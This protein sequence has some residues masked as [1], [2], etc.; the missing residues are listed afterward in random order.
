M[1]IFVPITIPEITILRWMKLRFSLGGALRAE[2]GK[3]GVFKV[4]LGYYTAQDLGTNSSDPAK[5]NKRLGSDIE[6]LGE[7]YISASAADTVL[8]I[9]R[10]RL[11]TPFANSGDA[12]VIP[13]SFEGGS[14]KNK[15]ISNLTIELNHINTIKN[16]NS[17]EFIDV[18]KWS[19]GR[20]GVDVASTS[21]DNDT[22]CCL[23]RRWNQTS[24]VGL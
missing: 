24:G 16:R 11:S 19:T 10:Q 6:V 8:T 22:R 17:D 18:G 2:T 7:A 20:Y 21:G 15:G 3:I 14:I 23:F 4:G 12:F 5:V 13:F 1:G 9:G